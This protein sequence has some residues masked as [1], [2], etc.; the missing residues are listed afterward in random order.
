M[1][2]ARIPG[3]VHPSLKLWTLKLW[4]GLPALR[5]CVS[6][7]APDSPPHRLVKHRQSGADGNCRGCV[8]QRCDHRHRLGLLAAGN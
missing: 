1:N 7:C 8:L 6:I 5:G 3:R 2:P 4:V